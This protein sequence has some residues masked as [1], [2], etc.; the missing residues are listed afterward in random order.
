MLMVGMAENVRKLVPRADLEVCV[1][2]DVSV[3]IKLIVTLLMANVTV[4]LDGLAKY[5]TESVRLVHLVT[6][7]LTDVIV[8]T[9]PSVI[10][11]QENVFV[12]QDG[13]V[14]A[15]NKNVHRLLMDLDA[16]RNVAVKMA[17]F[18]IT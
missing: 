11:C 9:V 14:L 13:E 7:V 16:H 5:V 1:C 15:V 10:L 8:T 2:H 4:P 12:P 17:Q 18:V 3:R 6:T